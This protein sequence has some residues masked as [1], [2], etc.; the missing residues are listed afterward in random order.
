MKRIAIIFD[1]RARPETT[2]LYCRRALGEMVH[3]GQLIEVE[4][5]L[6]DESPHIPANR[7]DLFLFIDDGLLQHIPKHLKPSAWWAIDTHLEY[8]RALS[9]AREADWSFAAQRP[10]AIRLQSD[11]VVNASWL[12]LACDPAIHGQRSTDVKYDLAFVGHLF[13]GER[14]RLLHLIQKRYPNTFIGNKYLEQMAQTYSAS[15][16]VFNRSLADDINMR[17]FEGLCSGSLL[18]TNSLPEAGQDELFQ[19][20]GHYANYT[21][22][23]E[24][25]E[26]IEYYLSHDQKRCQ[27]AKQGRL[28]VLKLHTY[29]HRM[30]TI[31]AAVTSQHPPGI[32][33]PE[34]GVRSTIEAKQADYFEH[35]RPDVLELIPETA[36]RILEIGCGSGMLGA[37]I[38]Q[39]QPAYVAG[40]EYDPIAAGRASKRLDEVFVGD[41]EAGEVSFEENSFDCIICADVLEHLRDPASVLKL[42]RGWLKPEGCMV[43]SLPNVRNHTVIQSLLAGNW[44]YESAGLLDSDHV[45]FF[46]RREIEKLLF[47]TGFT[48]DEMQ[49]IGGDGYAEWV[50]SGSPQ[51]LSIA[52]LQI[53]TSS[54]EEA[55][56][57]FAYQY[58][59]RSKLSR[60]PEYDKTSIIIV[61][62]NQLEY[63]RQC[64]Q[65]ILLRTD[66]PYELIFID[67][68]SSDGTAQ[69]LHS[70]AN[71]TI[72][73]N[74]ENR[75]F[76]AAV[77]QGI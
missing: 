55:A 20:G 30:E 72:I 37:S 43:T 36:K 38:K 59:T 58:L 17:V 11:G 68:A 2:G 3:A 5:F 10:G 32:H 52:G 75:G 6:P 23:E 48:V 27:I 47:Q 63:T 53:K 15:R 51:E 26:K 64:V 46:T 66:E 60:S 35:S 34:N 69:Y 19:E 14:E 76:P 12:P 7:F 8:E 54:P 71:A 57:F 24:L 42:L 25:W 73:C 56:E 39:R 29:R 28:E 9:M 61:T 67:N 74:E 62:Y 50:H 22:E 1:N 65:S 13:P 70:L 77:N 18:L 45:R 40:V 16:I 33:L 49:M 44:T 4:H 41:I 31:L 21:Q